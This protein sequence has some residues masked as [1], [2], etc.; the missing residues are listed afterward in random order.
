MKKLD[1]KSLLVGFVIAIIGMIGMTS[2]YASTVIKSAS[3]S[4]A[5]VTINGTVVSLTKPLVAIAMENEQDAGLY[6]PVRELLE[7]LGYTASWDNSSR[8]VNLL[9]NQS[10]NNS[11]EVIG[12]VVGNNTTTG[13][14]VINLSNKKAFNIAES[15]SFQAENNTTLVLEITSTVKGGTVDLFLF[16]PNKREQR[17]TIGETT[18]TKEITLSK[19][20]WQYNC[21][22]MFSDGGNIRIVGII[23]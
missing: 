8:T 4:N 5:R 12:N 21:T 19:G 7:Y 20:L 2:V 14:V 17:I 16:D 23:K 1:M 9:Q 10:A 15:G 18:T 6:M 13:E 22:G 11:H 3:V